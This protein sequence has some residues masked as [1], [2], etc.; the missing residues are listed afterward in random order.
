MSDRAWLPD[1]P[2]AAAVKERAP[3]PDPS[4]LVADA[5]RAIRVVLANGLAGRGLHSLTSQLNL[6]TFG[7]TSLTL[8]LDYSTFGTRPRAGLGHVGDI[9]SLS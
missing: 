8:E 9:V 3:G 6:R 7:N 2:A 4:S 1:P 5:A